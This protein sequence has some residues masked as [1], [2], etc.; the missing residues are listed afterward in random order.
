M[1]AAQTL[2]FAALLKRHRRAAGLTQEQLAERA[3]YSVNYISLLER[4]RRLPIPATVELLAVALGL[5]AAER[6]TLLE[7]CHAVKHSAVIPP[8]RAETRPLRL[9]G[10]TRELTRLERHLAGKLPP[11]LLLSGE[12][13]IGKTRLLQ[14][15]AQRAQERGLQVLPGGC[16][17]RSG[18]EPYAH[19]WEP[20]RATSATAPPR[21]CAPGWKDAPGWCICS[22][23]WPRPLSCRRPAMG[24]HPSRSGG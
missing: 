7:A 18:Q 24:W 21:S 19:C 22:Q 10:R 1:A 15:I 20:S 14:E 8:P 13:G 2:S 11:L 23:S 4:G 5:G 3:G 6:V 9:V 17:R 16:N 12:P